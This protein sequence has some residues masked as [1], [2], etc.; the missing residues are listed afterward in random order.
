MAS[1]PRLHVV[2]F[3]CQM[4]KLD[5]EAVAGQLLERG[6]V[7]VEEAGEADVVLIHTCSVRRHAEDKVW[8]LLGTLR[9]HKERRPGLVVAVAGCMAQREREAILERMPHVDVVCGTMELPRLPGLIAAARE[10][11]GPALAVAQRPDVR[12]PRIV[13][14]RPSRFQAYVAV[15]RGCDNFCSYCVVPYVRGRE[16]SRPPDEIEDEVRRLADDGCKEV[17]LLG[18]NVNSYGRSL[19]DGLT[20]AGLLRR[21]AP[22]G[23]LERLRFVTSHPK[24]ATDELF[25]AMA[26]LP[27]VCP[28]LHMPAQ[29]GSNRVLRDMHRRYTREYYLER[30]A[31]L[32]QRVPGAEVAGDFIV[33]F[34]GETEDEFE[35]T[36][37]LVG[38]VEYLNCFVF[39]YSPRPGTRAA[40]MADD[41]PWETK[42]ERNRRLLA[43][44]EAIMARHQAA[45]VGRTVRV[46]VEGPSKRDPDN[47][48][49]RTPGNRI[50][51]FPG[52][53]KLAGEMV[54]VEV[55][56]STPLTL[57]GRRREG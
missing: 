12:V 3:G 30:V 1:P 34:P 51:A 37:D 27:P 6:Y 55:V 45:F 13:P 38:R 43:V 20:L 54:D 4:N 44:Q 53:A 40:E 18:Q 52:E 23:G 39:K 41:V 19:G 50:V 47:L 56:D 25:Q 10:G 22:I 33:G 16:H 7:P 49:G 32:R 5:S 17:T 36:L 28:Y 31:A 21:L 9:R 48:T 57:L 46:L 15:M 24:D 29:A 8:S 26:D 42:R 14:R 35:Q 2:T 11:R